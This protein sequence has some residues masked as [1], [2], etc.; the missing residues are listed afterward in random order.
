MTPQPQTSSRA[1][2]DHH[3]HD[4]TRVPEQQ[5]GPKV[6]NKAT[7]NEQNEDAHLGITIRRGGAP[8]GAPAVRAAKVDLETS[9]LDARAG[10]QV[11]EICHLDRGQRV[12]LS[13]VGRWS[14]C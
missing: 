1:T 7:S 12:A 9:R 5:Q 14:R 3:E 8:A 11:T 13:V 6:A 2:N 4:K 10:G